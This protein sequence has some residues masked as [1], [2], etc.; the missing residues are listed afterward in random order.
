MPPSAAFNPEKDMPDLAGKV[1]LI[2]GGTSP[3]TRLRSSVNTTYLPYLS[4][5]PFSQVPVPVPKEN[6]NQYTHPIQAPQA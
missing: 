3:S 5:N 4:S 1:I 2:T 6:T